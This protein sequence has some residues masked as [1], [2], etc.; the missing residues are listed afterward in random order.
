[1]NSRLFI[2]AN[3]THLINVKNYI[4]THEVCRNYVIS[5]ITYFEGYKSF[6]EAVDKADEVELLKTF[7]I[8]QGKTGFSLY[9]DILKKMKAI[10]GLS[11]GNMG[12]KE[13]LF[14]NYNSWLQN[15]LVR[16]SAAKKRILM[17]DGTAIFDIVE[18]R[19]K[20]KNIPFKGNKIFIKH[21]LRLKPIQNLHFYSQVQLKP[22]T[23]DSLEVF[24]FRASNTENIKQKKIYFVGSP[25]VELEYISS[26]KNLLMLQ[27]LRDKFSQH[28][29]YYFA[30]RRE[31][32]ENLQKYGFIDEIVRDTIPFEERLILEEEL[33]GL[34]VSYLSSV[35]INLPAVY[36]KINFFYIPIDFKDI[37]NNNF[38]PKYVHLKS[39]FEK[40]GSKNFKELDLNRN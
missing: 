15:F 22:A 16:K 28:K 27:S 21:I 34:I 36:P 31:S 6:E 18:Y 8:D 9:M 12:F 11:L 14:T 35:L 32:D 40:I 26:E 4:D 33:P 39:N 24:N 5:T 19:K 2:I 17:S 30:H 23:G 10:H 1:M 13:V 29:I 3:P 37:T 25:L 38:V 20:N 7:Y